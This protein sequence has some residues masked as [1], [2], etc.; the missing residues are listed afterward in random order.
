MCEE[1][2][3][4]GLIVF[5]C[6]FSMALFVVFYGFLFCKKNNTDM[7]AF[8]GMLEMYRRIFMFENKAFSIL[9]LS[10]IY[11]GALLGL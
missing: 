11:G 8:S 6:I 9:M 3:I 7:N 5:F 10:C 1:I 4:A 2:R